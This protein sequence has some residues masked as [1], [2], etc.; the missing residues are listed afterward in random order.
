MTQTQSPYFTSILLGNV[1]KTVKVGRKSV[2]TILVPDYYLSKKT[3]KSEVDA[4]QVNLFENDYN[5]L[6]K[7]N[8]TFQAVMERLDNGVSSNNM[9]VDIK[10]TMSKDYT[11]NKGVRIFPHPEFKLIDIR[12]H[13]VLTSTKLKAEST[14]LEDALE[15]EMPF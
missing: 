2:L 1:T 14:D 11:N 4:Y 3:G 8:A 6:M 12:E 9:E 7:N 15:E 10:I 5:R 13:D